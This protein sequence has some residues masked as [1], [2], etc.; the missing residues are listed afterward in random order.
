MVQFRG[1]STELSDGE[2]ALVKIMRGR[3][4]L[5]TAVVTTEF[6]ERGIGPAN[7]GKLTFNSLLLCIDRSGGRGKFLVTLATD[8]E[9]GKAG[10]TEQNRH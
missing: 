2:R 8:L 7:A 1:S 5:P 4:S 10:A 9:S 3:G 6:V